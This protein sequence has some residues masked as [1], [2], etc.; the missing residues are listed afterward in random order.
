MSLKRFRR[1]FPVTKKMIYLDHAANG[2]CSILVSK[3]I[4][5]F[6]SEWSNEGIDW[7]KWYHHIS[8]GKK[9]FSKL[10]HADPEEIAMVP[11][12]S[13]GVS[14]AA[15]IVCASRKGNI[16]LND[17]EFPANVY[18]WLA[19]EK[20]G[21]AI[22]YVRSRKGIISA[23]DFE[24]QVDDDTVA[25]PLSHVSYVSGLRHDVES[26]AENI[27]KHGGLMVVDAIQSAGALEIDVKKQGID[28]LT[29][30]CSKWILG[31]HGTG[32]LFVR[33]GLIETS[34]PTLIGWHSIQNPFDFNLRSLRLS[35]TA[36]RFEP[37]SPNFLGFVGAGAALELLLTVGQ[38][39][40]QKE[41]LGLTGYLIDELKDL[42]VELTTPADPNR[43][44]G[45]VNFKV[46]DLSAA[47]NRLRRKRIAVSSRGGGIRVS[48]HFYNTIEELDS[49]VSALS[50]E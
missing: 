5:K 21:I 36:T 23:E 41:I 37:G 11:N 48:P 31:P 22:R 13:T 29:S 14:L 43:R 27:H 33:R 17:L 1:I 40:I 28:V 26:I 10:I 6:L 32:F 39:R 44:A 34:Q 38:K 12:T 4:Q 19:K 35:P 9:L 24:R 7:M 15:E 25:V 47:M 49:L 3:A 42:S 2:P 20:Q 8:A 16:V 18:P 30:G 50:K 46:R 45:I